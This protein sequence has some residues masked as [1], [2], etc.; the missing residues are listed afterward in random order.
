VSYNTRPALLWWL[1]VSIVA[2]ALIIVYFVVS[3]GGLGSRFVGLA[4]FV[5]IGNLTYTIY[6][7]HW[8]VYVALSPSTTGWSYW[9]LEFLRL[10]IIFGVALASWFLVERPLMRWRRRALA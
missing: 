10:A 1:P 6:L 5:L 4:P 7:V 2:S 3:P 8:P 9:P